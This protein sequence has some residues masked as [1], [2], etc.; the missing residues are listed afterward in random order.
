M[1]R[2]SRRVYVRPFSRAR[3]CDLYYFVVVVHY[4]YFV[5]IYFELLLFYRCESPNVVIILQRPLIAAIF[6]I[7]IIFIIYIIIYII[8]LSSYEHVCYVF[9]HF[10][11]II[12]S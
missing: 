5:F 2:R 3:F 6:V 9:I 8:S 11:I 10:V 1:R 12:I 7:Y 4:N